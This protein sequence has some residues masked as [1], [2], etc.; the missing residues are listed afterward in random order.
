MCVRVGVCCAKHCNAKKKKT[1]C[2]RGLLKPPPR[3]LH[4]SSGSSGAFTLANCRKRLQYFTRHSILFMIHVTCVR[5][6]SM[7]QCEQTMCSDCVSGYLHH[8]TGR[9]VQ[10]LLIYE[11][12]FSF[13]EWHTVES[14]EG[15]MMFPKKRGRGSFRVQS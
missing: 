12:L 14:G 8:N 9:A 15:G 7:L 6:Q 10:S 2:S 4:A 5:I 3:F 13:I 1:Q 11:K